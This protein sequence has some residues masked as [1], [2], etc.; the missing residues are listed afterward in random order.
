[1]TQWL[2]PETAPKDGSLLRLLVQFTEHP[3]EDDDAAPQA[4]VGMNNL[5]NTGVDEWQFAGWCWT[6][7][8]FTQGEG[9]VVGWLPLL[10]N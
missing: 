9:T 1:M 8:R 10:D 6:H 5:G 7:D 4:T 3:M 2:S